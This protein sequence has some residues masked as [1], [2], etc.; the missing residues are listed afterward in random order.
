MRKL[1]C[2]AFV[3]LLAFGATAAHAATI[4]VNLMNIKPS[5]DSYFS[6]YAILPTV[7]AGVEVQAN[8]NNWSEGGSRRGLVEWTGAPLGW[9]NKDD[10]I[11]VDSDGTDTSLTFAESISDVW[12]SQ[13]DNNGSGDD[14]LMSATSL[15]PESFTVSNVPYL[16]YDLIVYVL[17][18]D[19]GGV[20]ELEIDDGTTTYYV[21]PSTS[22]ETHVQMTN[23]TSTADGGTPDEGTYVKFTGLTGN[24]TI[25][26]SNTNGTNNAG[27]SGFQI[28]PEP[29]TLALLGLGGLGVLIR[30]KRR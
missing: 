26:W 25:S 29:A 12:P 14:Q 8:W 3:A 15:A 20:P 9:E 1:A 18:R 17:D 28:V 10:G 11:F 16:T 27:V 19:H 7:S 23:T 21:N 2:F 24:T 22:F 13:D 5:D 4:G 30:R 6:G